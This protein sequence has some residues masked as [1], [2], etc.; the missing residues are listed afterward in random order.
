VS[1]WEQVREGKALFPERALATLVVREDG[2]DVVNLE[3]LFLKLWSWFGGATWQMGRVSF[4]I[5][6]G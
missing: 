6:G 1:A 3:V 4:L 5:R 2:W